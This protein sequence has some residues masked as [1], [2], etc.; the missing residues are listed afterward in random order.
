MKKVPEKHRLLLIHWRNRMEQP[1]NG[2]LRMERMT[3]EDRSDR[4]EGKSIFL[5]LLE[6][7]AELRKM[8]RDESRS[9]RNNLPTISRLKDPKQPR[10]VRRLSRYIE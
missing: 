9:L 6:I 8:A 2:R 4:Q 5:R 1:E 10:H 3:P 7:E